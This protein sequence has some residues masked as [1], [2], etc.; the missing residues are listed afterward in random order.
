VGYFSQRRSGI[1][2]EFVQEDDDGQ[3][4]SRRG[5]SLPRVDK[6]A[7]GT[8]DGQARIIFEN[9]Q[10]FTKTCVQV[11]SGGKA[12]AGWLTGKGMIEH[13]TLGRLSL[14]GGGARRA[15]RCGKF[16]KDLGLVRPAAAQAFSCA[17]IGQMMETQNVCERR[18][19]RPS[20]LPQSHRFLQEF[21]GP[22]LKVRRWAFDSR[23]REA[24]RQ[25][26]D[27]GR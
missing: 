9:T 21:A 26:H 8:D 1:G 4:D 7:D 3:I 25:P 13:D 18:A 12:G 15:R 14:T 17:A 27:G 23:S 5:G 20:K 19:S 22:S 16:R 2:F 11:V 24:L 6:L 10:E